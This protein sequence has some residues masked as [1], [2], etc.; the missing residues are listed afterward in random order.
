MPAAIAELG[1]IFR[2]YDCAYIYLENVAKQQENCPCGHSRQA[3]TGAESSQ[4]GF[5]T[6]CVC[7]RFVLVT[8][9][10]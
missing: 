7:N 1:A 8:A 2:T 5:C 4:K 3:H 6:K 10:V 9:T